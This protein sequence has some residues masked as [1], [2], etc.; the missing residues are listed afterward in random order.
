MINSN[1]IAQRF[2]IEEAKGFEW[3]L[4][5]LIKRLGWTVD[6]HV[7]RISL[8]RVRIVFRSEQEPGMNMAWQRMVVG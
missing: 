5:N 4:R 7:F 6:G 8:F 1:L 2:A 3:T